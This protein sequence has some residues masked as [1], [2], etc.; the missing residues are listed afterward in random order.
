MHKND[1][2]YLE[3]DHV[4]KHPVSH[5][6]L[7]RLSESCQKLSNKFPRGPVQWAGNL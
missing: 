7:K 2:M 4:T 1:Q 5:P 3:C 6:F